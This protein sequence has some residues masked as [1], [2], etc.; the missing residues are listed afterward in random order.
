MQGQSIVA[1]PTFVDYNATTRPGHR[2]VKIYAD[3][4]SDS[5]VE[6]KNSTI[7]LDCM[8]I[9]TLMSDEGVQECNN[10]FEQPLSMV[11]SFGKLLTGLSEGRTSKLVTYC[12]TYG[13]LD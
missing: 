5:R 12:I 1:D 13:K 2:K 4:G 8:G 6:I 10:Y 11:N 3:P 7:Q 9:N